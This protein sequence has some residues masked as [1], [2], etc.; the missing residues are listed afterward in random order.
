MVLSQLL[1]HTCI[2]L[3]DIVTFHH[4]TVQ[5]NGIWGDWFSFCLQMATGGKSVLIPSKCTLAVRPEPSSCC[6]SLMP[7]GVQ[8]ERRD[9]WI[10]TNYSWARR[11]PVSMTK[12]NKIHYPVCSTDQEFQVMQ[13]G[14][15]HGHSFLGNNTAESA[16]PETWSWLYCPL[17]WLSSL[18]F[19]F[20]SQISQIMAYLFK[21]HWALNTR[22]S[23]SRLNRRRWFFS[24]YK[25]SGWWLLLMS[26]RWLTK[27]GLWHWGSLWLS[28][29][30][31]PGCQGSNV[32]P[33][34]V[35]S[36]PQDQGQVAGYYS[37]LPFS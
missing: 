36:H 37:P 16:K 15:T 11:S 13:F 6:Y 17:W 12:Y 28:W 8:G 10:R 21:I 1:K 3:R 25:K 5:F 4:P 9:R 20:Y 18:S 24:C 22:W 32:V 30:Y 2:L 19:F 29:S 34:S 7:H 33:R 14:C 26:P 27:S 31:P 23:D 35:C